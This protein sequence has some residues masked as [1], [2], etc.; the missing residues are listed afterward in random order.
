M[1]LL[2]FKYWLNTVLQFSKHC[3][4]TFLFLFY[5]CFAD[6]QT[7]FEN[8]SSLCWSTV[9]FFK[10][11]LCYCL[12]VVFLFLQMMTCGSSQRFSGR[13]FCNAA[14]SICVV[15]L[16]LPRLMAPLHR[17][18]TNFYCMLIPITSRGRPVFLVVSCHNLLCQDWVICTLSVHKTNELQNLPSQSPGAYDTGILQRSVRA[19]EGLLRLLYLLKVRHFVRAA[20]TLNDHIKPIHVGE[21]VSAKGPK[22][23]FDGSAQDNS[24]VK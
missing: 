22:D 24:H 16:V 2:L 19:A 8:V 9:H 21:C 23:T 4:N 1:V 3:S 13:T 20:P 15:A 5:Y 10:Y 17:L 14:T 12:F 18:T 6:F 11:C 7:L